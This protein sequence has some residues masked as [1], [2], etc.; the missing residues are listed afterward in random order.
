MARSPVILVRGRPRDS[1][2][3]GGKKDGREP[4][5][6]LFRATPSLDMELRESVAKPGFR[7][8]RRVI[9]WVQSVRNNPGR[10]RIVRLGR[11]LE[12]DQNAASGISAQPLSAR[13]SPQPKRLVSLCGHRN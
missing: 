13:L 6:T 7:G 8:G 12:P 11:S 1:E 5:P 9:R 2:E 4:I 10:T 3:P